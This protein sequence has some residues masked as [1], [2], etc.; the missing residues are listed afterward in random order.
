MANRNKR[1]ERAKLAFVIAALI[2]SIPL[3]QLAPATARPMKT[4]PP[5]M[6][7]GPCAPETPGVG[8]EE[9]LAPTPPE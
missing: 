5:A 1:K 4:V 2:G 8:P 6:Q 3:T 7:P 9:D